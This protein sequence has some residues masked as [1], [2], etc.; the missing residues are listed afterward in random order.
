MTQ[1]GSSLQSG[2]TWATKKTNSE[3]QRAD[4]SRPDN[5]NQKQAREGGKIVRCFLCFFCFSSE[6]KAPDRLPCCNWCLGDKES[7]V[8]SRLPLWINEGRDRS[9]RRARR[10]DL[11]RCDCA[12]FPARG[13]HGRQE[14]A[15]GFPHAL[16]RNTD[17]LL[18]PLSS[19]C[20]MLVI[21]AAPAPPLHVKIKRAPS[22]MVPLG[23]TA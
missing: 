14:A 11:T 20:P 12:V 21:S 2:E 10:H 8:P 5:I 9:C 6:I 23:Q 15:D 3:H 1:L 18:H 22:G 13:E 7:Q 16:M 17:L 4:E 19:L